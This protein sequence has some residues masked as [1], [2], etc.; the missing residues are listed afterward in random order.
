MTD[1]RIAVGI[2][3]RDRRD[4]LLA[5]VARL[6]ALPEQPQ[7][8]VVD[9]GS[10]DGSGAALR[11]AHPDVEVLEAVGRAE[12]VDPVCE[13][14][15]RSPL[16]RA[17]DAVG[18]ALLGFVAC[19]VVVRA[20]AF[21]D[22]GG[23]RPEV[24]GEEELLAMDLATEGWQLAYVDDIVAHHHPSRSRDPQGRRRRQEVVALWTALQR[25]PIVHG[26]RAVRSL[27]HRP[28][29]LADAAVGLPWALANRQ[30][31]PRHHR[32]TARAARRRDR[33]R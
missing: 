25:R 4:E 26:L 27:L 2:I 24:G 15:R 9:N 10:S 5:T 32:G 33:H 28:R 14:M 6:R 18:P 3:T 23:F 8:V 20:G 17:D 31:V 30:A 29:T 22:A 1:S 21:L 12:Q 16:P 11:A 13:Q 19:G 7:V